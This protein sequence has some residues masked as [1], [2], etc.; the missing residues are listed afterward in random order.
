MKL[1]THSELEALRRLRA[2]FL[3]GSA[4]GAD[5]WK[6][7]EDLALYDAT[8]AARIG[9]KVDAAL[10]SAH[11]VGW[12]PRSTRV[13]DWGCGSGIA[14]RRVIAMWPGFVQL[15][16]HDR[17]ARAV[18]FARKHAPIPA[19]AGERV[20]RDTLLVLSHVLNELAPAALEHVLEL[21]RAAG[22]VVWIEAGTHADSRRL[23]EV[24]ER[25]RAEW[26]IVAPCT[27]AASCGLLAAENAR[28]WCHHFASA[29]SAVFQDAKW[30]DFSRAIG[31]DLRSLPY[32]YL[33]LDRGADAL[34]PGDASRIIGVPRESKGYCRILSCQREG[35]ADLMLQKRD[36][37]ALFRSV[38]REP[39]QPPHR[40]TMRGGRIVDGA[41]LTPRDA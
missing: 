29:P 5:Y 16:V 7:D 40:W 13:L 18:E 19:E 9:W 2:G 41:P 22:E 28:H 8:F 25:L 12:R 23:I 30:A 17:S 20:D 31:I 33:V 34:V 39:E 36:A 37:P 15:A 10:R 24:R 3:A 11:A 38:L 4:G 21:V 27:H 14:G 1:W 35:V 6:S 26:R 32:S